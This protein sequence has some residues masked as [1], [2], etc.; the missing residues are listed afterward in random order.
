MNPLENHINLEINS[1]IS[2]F[3]KSRPSGHSICFKSESW[4]TCYCSCGVS[5]T[6]KPGSCGPYIQ[7]AEEQLCEMGAVQALDHITILSQWL[8]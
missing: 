2:L 1:H 6:R 7:G 5:L 4:G 8:T 3:A